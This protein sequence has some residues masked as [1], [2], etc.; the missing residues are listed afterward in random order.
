MLSYFVFTQVPVRPGA[1]TADGTDRFG[2]AVRSTQVPVRGPR[3]GVR[4]LPERAG[5]AEAGLRAR[6]SAGRQ[7][8]LP[9]EN[10]SP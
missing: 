5:A 6:H 2:H 7:L 1:T 4:V 8:L 10:R 9:G 3:V